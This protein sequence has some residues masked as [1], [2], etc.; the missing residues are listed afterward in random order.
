MP[1]HAHEE[2]V[3]EAA[4]PAEGLQEMIEPIYVTG[5]QPPTAGAKPVGPLVL[6]MPFEEPD[7][8]V[9]Q[10]FQRCEMSVRVPVA[11]GKKGKRLP[12]YAL[13]IYLSSRP[14]SIRN[15]F[16]CLPRM[17]QMSPWLPLTG[18]GG[19]PSRLPLTVTP[20]ERA[21]SV[22]LNGPG[23]GE[24]FRAGPYRFRILEGGAATDGRLGIVEF[25]LPPA[26]PSPPQHIH[27]EHDESFL[28]V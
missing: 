3:A 20:G 2:Q 10:S 27:R 8:L 6:A 5:S 9:E 11:H 25:T 24:T 17:A 18:S 26:H 4:H 12:A 7:G 14:G 21:V 16:E 23:E 13:F 28:V 22:V 1:V 19:L 15:L